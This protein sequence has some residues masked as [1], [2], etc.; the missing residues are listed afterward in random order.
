MGV[1]ITV[2]M[3]D[4]VGYGFLEGGLGKCAKEGRFVRTSRSGGV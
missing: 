3:E 2:L 4:I 1:E